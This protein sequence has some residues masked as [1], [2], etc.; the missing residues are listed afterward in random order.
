MCVFYLFFLSLF[1]VLFFASGAI[2]K[3][4]RVLVS[5]YVY[6]GN[7][8]L[9]LIEFGLPV[10]LPVERLVVFMFIFQLAES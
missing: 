6:P 5:S 8:A 3:K 2:K 4:K 9:P 7:H 1:S 10:F